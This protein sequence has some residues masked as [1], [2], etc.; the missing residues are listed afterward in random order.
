[1]DESET[2]PDWGEVT[3]ADLKALL[4]D[5]R[6]ILG[7]PWGT[8]DFQWIASLGPPVVGIAIACF[9]PQLPQARQD[10]SRIWGSALP[11]KDLET[12]IALLE[13]AGSVLGN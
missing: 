5:E 13:E 10:L 6:H 9:D 12:C 3:T 11:L 2:H 8:G 4:N 1:M 7:G